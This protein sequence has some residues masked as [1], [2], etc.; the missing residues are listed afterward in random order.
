MFKKTWENMAKLAG[1]YCSQL[2]EQNLDF[3]AAI[4]YDLENIGGSKGVHSGKK[5]GVQKLGDSNLSPQH[6]ISRCGWL[7]KTLHS[8][9]D[10]WTSTKHSMEKSARAIY[11]WPINSG[12]FPPRMDIITTKKE[13][14][15]K[16][17]SCLLGRHTGLPVKVQYYLVANGIRWFDDFLTV[18]DDEPFKKYRTLQDKKTKHAFVMKVSLMNNRYCQ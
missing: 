13:L 1:T 12:G 17:V 9:F 5:F 4:K 14:V 10:Y 16:F 3:D 7:V 2:R 15:P 8:F 6:L 11:D 18:L